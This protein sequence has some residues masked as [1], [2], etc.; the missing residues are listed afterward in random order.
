MSVF[1][2]NKAI[3]GLG[4]AR[5]GVYIAG[6]KT[7]S[8]SRAKQLRDL[9]IHKKQL[10]LVELDKKK[11]DL[12]LKKKQEADKAFACGKI[13]REVGSARGKDP[14]IV[15]QLTSELQ[16]TERQRDALRREVSGLEM[17]VR[18][19]ESESR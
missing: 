12:I 16:I 9:E 13:M 14:Q 11:R 5:D 1:G 10:K 19:L 8:L 7:E 3:G 4:K 15:R 18:R 17:E 6:A 2:G